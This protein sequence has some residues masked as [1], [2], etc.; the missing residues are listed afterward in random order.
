MAAG[1]EHA[2]RRMER[3][4]ERI[5]TAVERNLEAYPHLQRQLRENLLKLEDDY[6][7]TAEIPSVCPTGS[8]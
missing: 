7:K 2:E 6:Q 5:G 8:R 1:V 4:F 3:E